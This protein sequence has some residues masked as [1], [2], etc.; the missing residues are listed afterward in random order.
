[1][2]DTIIRE[3]DSIYDGNEERPLLICPR[4]GNPDIYTMPELQEL[5]TKGKVSFS[6][7][8]AKWLQA[9]ERPVYRI[10][11]RHRLA[12][13]NALSF[14]AVCVVVLTVLTFALNHAVPSLPVF[15]VYLLLGMVIGVRTYRTEKKVAAREDEIRTD[16]HLARYRA[17]LD[18][19]EVWTRLRYCS[20]CA[21]VIDL[22]TD[23]TTSLFDVHELTNSRL[24]DGSSRTN[25]PKDR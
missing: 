25:A 20:K 11:P 15:L 21:V 17:Y 5:V 1:M 24:H 6:A 10:S 8:L 13:R 14:G 4:C 12:Q 18:R 23:E 7:D 19:N 2:S 16:S 3:M 22:V 9:P